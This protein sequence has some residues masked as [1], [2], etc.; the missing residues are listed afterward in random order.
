MNRQGSFDKKFLRGVQSIFSKGRNLPGT[1][2]VS[3]ERE[4]DKQSQPSAD[5]GSGSGKGSEPRDNEKVGGQ[6]QSSAE[7]K[8]DGGGSEP[9][10]PMSP[11]GDDNLTPTDRRYEKFMKLLKQS[12]VDLD[13]LRELS[14]GGIPP[15]LRP[16]CWRLLLGYMPPNVDRREAV[17]AR[18]RREYHD[19]IPQYYDIDNS[20]RTEEEQA[21]LRQIAVDIPRTVSSVPFVHLPSSQSMLQRLLYIWAIRHPASGYVQGINDLVTPF[22]AVFISEHCGQDMSAW[23]LDELPEHVQQEIE[24]DCYWCTSML[25]DRIQDHYT[26]AQ[27]GIQRATHKLEELVK[28]IDSEMY[29]HCQSQNLQF[30]QFAFRWFNC[31]LLREVPFSGVYRLWD[32]YLAE[33]DTFPEYLIYVCASFFLTWSKEMKELEFQDMVCL[34]PQH[35][36]RVAVR[37]SYDMFCVGNTDYVPAA[38]ANG[39]VGS[40]GR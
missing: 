3:S 20:E 17:V 4:A 11:A 34:C 8:P 35:S 1:V 7:S 14:W 26:F 18:K 12:T 25:L 6:R 23:N 28:R 27:P 15:T 30:L 19:C 36:A 40:T 16:T 32:T 24:A 21:M 38:L 5:V 13:A 10:S 2:K 33:G 39:K 31:L 22:M 29:E 37:L 9:M